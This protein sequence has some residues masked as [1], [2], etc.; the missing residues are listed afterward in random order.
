MS[1]AKKTRSELTGPT[2]ATAGAYFDY[3][4]VE[5][6]VSENT[7]GS[8]RR[9]LA[10]YDAYL[11][12]IR[13]QDLRE[14]TELDITEFLA[15]LA[16]GDEARDVKPM[17]A[18]SVT[19]TLSAVRGL[20]KFALGEGDVD[21]DVAA[22]VNPPKQPS[23][24][25]K[26]LRIDEVETLI[27]SIP[28]GDVATV[29]DIRD[30]ALVELLYSTGARVSE[31]VGLDIDDID[32]EQHLVLLRGKGGKERI[33][34]VGG[35]AM[36]A[37]DAWL[38]R[39]RPAWV[40]MNSGPALFLNSLGRRLSRQSCGNILSELAGRAGLAGRVSPHT[41]RHS[42]ATHLMEGGADVRVVQELLGHSSVTT[43]QIY[44]MVTADNLRRVW[45]GAHPRAT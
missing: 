42:F 20:H 8:Y 5:K 44:T 12:G 17:A 2:A 31:V 32:R 14:V 10:K 29:S 11:R 22:R 40:R 36:E 43:T 35:L 30:K 9:D 4:A 26:A 13:R 7:L 27:D 3:L 34:P 33:V 1:R 15:Y 18:S 45:A 23:R 24:L 19:R 39:G 16:K 28:A 37:V 25:P 41:L 6:G 21:V 38:I